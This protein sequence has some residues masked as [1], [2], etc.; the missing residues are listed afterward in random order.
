MRL[1][2][3]KEAAYHD[4]GSVGST[5][6]RKPRKPI[7]LSFEARYPG[8]CCS[9]GERIEVGDVIRYNADDEI[10]H[11]RHEIIH[12]RHERPEEVLAP[13]CP[14]CFMVHKGECL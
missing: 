5:V 4:T 2:R 13:P 1:S 12:A 10:V 3:H 7:P 6:V 9:C 14:D 11:A 8:T